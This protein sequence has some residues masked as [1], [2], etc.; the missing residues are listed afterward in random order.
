[1]PPVIASVAFS[2]LAATSA[3]TGIGI[4]AAGTLA[5]AI[6]QIGFGLA[7]AG[8]SY[9]LA[10]DEEKFD[11]VAENPG[12]LTE[13]EGRKLAVRQAVPTRRF[14]YGEVLTSGPMFFFESA[15]P[16]QETWVNEVAKIRH[17]TKKNI[18]KSP[19]AKP[20][21]AKI[22]QPGFK[23]MWTRR[24]LQNKDVFDRMGGHGSKFRR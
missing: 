19:I 18:R 5:T 6:G 14:L 2:A 12:F 17:Q 10:P 24:S 22:R 20:A 7:L 3:T 21:M 13:N 23:M 16:L 1:M 4:A 11:P 8:A 15:N 9:L